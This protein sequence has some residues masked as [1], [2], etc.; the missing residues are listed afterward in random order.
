MQTPK[1]IARILNWWSRAAVFAGALLALFALANFGVYGWQRL[2]RSLEYRMGG[3][4]GSVDFEKR[5]DLAKMRTLYPALSDPEIRDVAQYKHRIGLV[6]EPFVEIKNERGITDALA[7]HDWGFRLVGREQG[8]WPPDSAAFNIFV[9]GGEW[10]F[11]PSLTDDGTI[12]ALIQKNLREKLSGGRPINVYNFGTPT[13]YSVQERHF[14]EHLLIRGFVP[15]LAVFVDGLNEFVAWNGE[16]P[17]SD[18]MRAN[19]YK[20]QITN[21]NHEFGWYVMSGLRVLPLVR[22]IL[23]GGKPRA[24]EPVNETEA[25]D[26]ATIERIVDTYSRNRRLTQAVAAPFGVKT[27][28]VVSIAPSEPIGKGR[29]A[30]YGYPALAQRPESADMIWCTD[31]DYERQFPLFQQE[32]NNYTPAATLHVAQCISSALIERGAIGRAEVTQSSRR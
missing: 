1:S 3:A 28:H 18:W 6:Y 16:P 22:M 8:P 14:L 5:Y 12:P 9:F 26:P 17:L 24:G 30:K 4:A 19:F 2:S 27:A 29:R 11:G 23:G 15:D 25:K 13:H 31:F 10:V 21:F 32:T 7:V 20:A